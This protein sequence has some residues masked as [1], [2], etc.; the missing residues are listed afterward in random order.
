MQ[1]LCY[2]T[3]TLHLVLCFPSHIHGKNVLWADVVGI[4]ACVVDMPRLHLQVFFG[5]TFFAL[6]S[7][8][9]PLCF[10]NLASKAQTSDVQFSKAMGCKTLAD[11]A[12]A[13]TLDGTKWIGVV[14]S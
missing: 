1:V 12:P 13:T 6:K 9:A 7:G 11:G 14:Y 8:E 4:C 3:C 10:C 5:G 2:E